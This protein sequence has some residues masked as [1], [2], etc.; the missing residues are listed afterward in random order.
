MSGKAVDDPAFPKLDPLPDVLAKQYLERTAHM[1]KLS[2]QYNCM[3]SIGKVVYDFVP[4]LVIFAYF[5]I[6]DRY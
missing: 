1:S 5:Y 4:L 3:F 2:Q 6:H